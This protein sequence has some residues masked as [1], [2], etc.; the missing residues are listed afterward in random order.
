MR[1]KQHAA[2]QLGSR[3]VFQEGPRGL[4]RPIPSPGGDITSASTRQELAPRKEATSSLD[5]TSRAQRE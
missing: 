5:A 3:L 1:R 2:R 4:V